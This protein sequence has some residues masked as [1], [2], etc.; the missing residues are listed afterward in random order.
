MEFRDQAG[1]AAESQRRQILTVAARQLQAITELNAQLDNRLV[2]TARL[3]KHSLET[4]QNASI[5]VATDRFEAIRQAVSDEARGLSTAFYDHLSSGVDGL[6]KAIGSRFEAQADTIQCLNVAL[7]DATAMT[8]AGQARLT[9]ELRALRSAFE[10]KWREHDAALDEVL[11]NFA[12]LNRK[13]V[14]FPTRTAARVLARHYRFG[15]SENLT[16]EAHSFDEAS[17]LVE[18]LKAELLTTRAFVETVITSWSWMVTKPIRAAGRLLR[19]LTHR[20]S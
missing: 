3:L 15:D 14:R 20:V 7:T 1:H 11:Q 19:A 16:R 13:V 8:A 6:D 2:A 9:E 17:A 5:S 4:G 10:A 18:D 12:H